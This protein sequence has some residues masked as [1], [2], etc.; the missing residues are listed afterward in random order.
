MGFVLFVLGIELESITYSA[1][2]ILMWIIVLAGQIYIEVPTA[3]DTYS[4]MAIFGVA[5]AFI[6]INVIWIVLRYME[7]QFEGNIRP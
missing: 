2:S 7:N 4:E 5:L 1:T 6:F 3:A